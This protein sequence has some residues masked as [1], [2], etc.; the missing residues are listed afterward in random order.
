[1][2]PQ[3]NLDYRVFIYLFIYLYHI[4]CNNVTV[5]S[6]QKRSGDEKSTEDNSFVQP[7]NKNKAC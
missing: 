7:Q 2:T 3:V 4:F 6:F 5:M 1:M